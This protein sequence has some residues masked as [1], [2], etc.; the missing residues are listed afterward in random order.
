MSQLSPQIP[1]PFD[2]LLT[3]TRVSLGREGYEKSFGVYSQCF[4]RL[5]QGHYPH[6]DVYGSPHFPVSRGRLQDHPYIKPPTTFLL[7]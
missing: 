4:F 2:D 7:G 3:L 6:G 5:I 1:S